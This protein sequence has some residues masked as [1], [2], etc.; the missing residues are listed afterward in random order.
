MSIHPHPSLPATHAPGSMRPSTVAGGEPTDDES[1]P[2]T[3][4][5]VDATLARSLRERRSAGLPLLVPRV[6]ED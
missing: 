2:S 3:P 5:G 4:P 6:A 1:P